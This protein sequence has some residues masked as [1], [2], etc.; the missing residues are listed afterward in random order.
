MLFATRVSKDVSGKASL[1]AEGAAYSHLLEEMAADPRLVKFHIKEAVEKVQEP[2]NAD[3][4]NIESLCTASD[5]KTL[6]I[7]FRSPVTDGRALLLPLTNAEEITRKDST[8]KA[9]FG[10]PVALDLGGRGLRDMIWHPSLGAYL[11]IGG[12]FD[13]HLDDPNAPKPNLFQWSGKAE[14]KPAMIDANL[15]ALNP[16]ALV[17]F[18]DKRVLILSD[19]GAFK[20]TPGISQK[21]EL[22]AKKKTQAEVFFRSVWLEGAP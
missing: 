15:D 5:G 17:L 11:L 20:A 2:K 12:H 9:A 21:D 4:L 22:K 3:A 8:A 13:E 1:S 10:E 6:L 18:P 16:E 19:D 7:G 14:D